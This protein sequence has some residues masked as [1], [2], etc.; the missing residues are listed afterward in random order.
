[1]KV[2]Y[3]LVEEMTATGEWETVGLIALWPN[4]SPRLQL[5]GMLQ[6]TVSRPIWKKIRQRINERQLSLETCHEALDEYSHIYRI[7]PKIHQITA[8]SAAEVRQQFRKKYIFESDPVT[9]G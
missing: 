4:D 1:M 7:L 2:S 5:R 8:K 9:I 3:R 6:H